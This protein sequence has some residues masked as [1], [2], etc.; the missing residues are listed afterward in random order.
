MMSGNGLGRYILRLD[1][2]LVEAARLP[3][4]IPRTIRLWLDGEKVSGPAEQMVRIWIGLHDRHLP[5]QP[6]GAAA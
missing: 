6:Y 5:W 1:F 3:C 2:S 4:E